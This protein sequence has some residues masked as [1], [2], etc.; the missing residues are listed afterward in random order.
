MH[1][2][3]LYDEA[4][5]LIED[6]QYKDAREILTSIYSY[7]DASKLLEEIK[8]ESIAFECIQ[9]IANAVSSYN[10]FSVNKV[11][12]YSKEYR[13]DDYTEEQKNKFQKYFDTLDDTNPLIIIEFRADGTDYY[14]AYIYNHS[15]NKYNFYGLAKSLDIEIDSLKEALSLLGHVEEL[16]TRNMIHMGYTALIPEGDID[17]NKVNRIITK[18]LA[19]VNAIQILDINTI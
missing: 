16:D 13:F 10:S 9:D 14:T 11:S 5:T 17:I 19:N 1:L 6:G 12:F 18:G 4:K 8:Y 15:N 3:I 2:Q 7:N